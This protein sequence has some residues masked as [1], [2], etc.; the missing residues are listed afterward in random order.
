MATRHRGSPIFT[1]SFEMRDSRERQLVTDIS[2]TEVG[3]NDVRGR[4]RTIQAIR[5]AN[6][7]CIFNSSRLLMRALIEVIDETATMPREATCD[8]H[9]QRCVLMTAIKIFHFCSTL[10]RAESN[11]PPVRAYIQLPIR[12]IKR[13]AKV[14]SIRSTQIFRTSVKSIE[15][16]IVARSR[17]GTFR[18]RYIYKRIL[19]RP[20]DVKDFSIRVMRSL[21]DSSKYLL[22]VQRRFIK[23]LRAI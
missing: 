18:F 1:F 21:I 23:L 8:S 14:I 15:T 9:R 16:S 11:N 7:R 10:D 13:N 17:N 4:R 2:S 5:T 19:V 20:N 3:N 12:L 22:P 6:N